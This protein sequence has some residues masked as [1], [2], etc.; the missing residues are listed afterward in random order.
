MGSPVRTI[1]RTVRSLS[2]QPIAALTATLI[3]AL[4]LGI[5]TALFSTARS[6]LWRPLPV[7]EPDDLVALYSH[8]DEGGYGSLSLPDVRDLRNGSRS[9]RGL[10]AYTDVEVALRSGDATSRVQAQLVTPDYF[11]V[12][13]LGA[14]SGRTF[15]P[16][17]P[18]GEPRVV[19]SNGLWKRLFGSD[20]TLV[21]RAVVIDGTPFTVLG[22]A[23]ARFTGTDPAV[24]AEA[25]IPLDLHAA[26]MPTFSPELIENRGTQWLVGIGRLRHGVP[27]AQASR[28]LDG[29]FARRPPDTGSDAGAWR[30]APLP[31]RSGTLWPPDRSEIVRLVR[32]AAGG[33]LLLLLVVTAN[34]SALLTVRSAARRKEM[35]LRQALGASR[36][37]LLRLVVIDSFV[38]AAAGVIA[39]FPVAFAVVRLLQ[40]T[41][42][43]TGDDPQRITVDLTLLAFTALVATVIALSSSLA[44]MLMTVRSRL[45]AALAEAATA[46][47]GG[48]G[49]PRAQR[50]FSVVQVALAVLLL[51]AD[52]LLLVSYG[53]LTRTDLGFSPRGVLLVS[54]DPGLS[55]VAS[56][57]WAGVYERLYRRVASVPGVETASLVFPAPFADQRMSRGLVVA[58]RTPEAD[59]Y[60][61]VVVANLVSPGYFETLGIPRLAGRDF[62]PGDKA[63]SPLVAI[64]NRKLA[65]TLWPRESA[66][67]R[68]FDLWDPAGANRPLNVVGVVA[69]ARQGR[70]VTE[71]EGPRLYLPLLQHPTGSATVVVRGR[72]DL[73]ALAPVLDTS[74]RRAM[75]ELAAFDPRPFTEQIDRS[76]RRPRS[77]AL[78]LSGIGVLALILSIA[79]LYG[80]LSYAWTQRAR[81]IGLRMALGAARGD[82]VRLVVRQGLVVTAMGIVLGL[83]PAAFLGRWLTPWLEAP[84]APVPVV[85]VLVAAAVTLAGFTAALLPALRAALADPIESLRQI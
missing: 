36:A 42:L 67:G 51:S 3:L 30:L 46:Q 1:G 20:P 25:W 80:L 38:L 78:I 79:G 26:V 11:Q 14:A 13:K 73:D 7:G 57:A 82:I 16:S 45:G 48:G 56:D 37:S 21:G 47:V 17:D 29:L 62:G 34:V 70:R 83:L 59:G 71:K 50:Y 81:E 52:A 19:L 31:G 69:D 12:L 22:I 60:T 84:T 4:G 65:E 39:A 44:P 23:P 49:N 76:L 74:L 66:V 40:N 33:A 72:G 32:L 77:A 61:D 2:R 24:A 41:R 55:G 8:D 43:A 58:G 85:L 63:D 9:L 54:V 28:E 75:P 35:A 68:R 18:G 10:A 15:S 64:V 6:L 5:G 27:L 53:R